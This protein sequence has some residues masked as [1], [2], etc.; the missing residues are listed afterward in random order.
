MQIPDTIN[1][2]ETNIINANLLKS[3]E[4]KKHELDTF[5]PSSHRGKQMK[6]L[7]LFC[8][9]LIGLIGA[10][11]SCNSPVQ[12]PSAPSNASVWEI[13]KNE[14]TLFLGGSVHILRAKDYPMPTAFDSAFGKAAILVL[15][16]DVDR[17]LDA[18]MLS[19]INDRWMLPEGQTLKTV[20]DDAVYRQLENTFGDLVINMVSHRYDRRHG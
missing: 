19:Y 6:R 5:S 4:G 1:S 20:L 10:F 2:R 12:D 15:E 17:I 8:I 13:S 7:S 3:I 9:V 11:T 16:T 14:N 18:E